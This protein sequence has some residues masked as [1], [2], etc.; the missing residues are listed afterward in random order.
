MAKYKVLA[1]VNNEEK[2]LILRQRLSRAEGVALV[3]FANVDADIMT[4]IKGY[5]P[6]IV[7]LVQE[8][9]DAGIMEL[10]Q[11]IYQG[12]PGCA[13]AMLV[14]SLDLELLKSA[15]QS[16]IRQIITEDNLATLNDSLVQAAL[17][18]QGRNTEVGGDPRVIVVYSGKGGVGRTTLAVNLAVALSLGGRRTALIDLNLNFGDAPLLLNINAKDTLAELTQEKTAFLIEDIKGFSMQHSSGLSIL[19]APSSPEFAEYIASRHVEMLLNT[20]RPYYDFIIVDLPNDLSENTLT[21]LESADDIFL[22]ARKDISS[23]RSTKILSGLLGTLQQQDKIKLIVNSDHSSI[24]TLKDFDRILQMPVSYALPE[25]PKTAQLSQ[26][27]GVPIVIGFPRSQIASVINKMA[28]DLM[29]RSSKK[30]LQATAEA[31]LAAAGKSISADRT[32]PAKA[33]KPHRAPKARL[34]FKMPKITKSPKAPRVPQSSQA[35]AAGGPTKTA[36]SGGFKLFGGK[37]GGSA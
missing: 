37:K 10:A 27:R 19:C 2:R 32:R 8:Q 28:R 31:N 15:M 22:V 3:G 1:V 12:F 20:M 9:G 14:P 7:L 17:F 6:H 23:L 11:R 21:A 18:E 33:A 26:E 35:P 29:D 13:I 34:T 4:R 24:V 16:G 30:E 5:A 25:E 36:K